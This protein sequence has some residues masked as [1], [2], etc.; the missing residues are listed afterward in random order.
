MIPCNV[1]PASEE[2]ADFIVRYSPRA[3]DSLYELAQTRCVNLVSQEYAIVHAPLSGVLP[4]SFT[5]HTYSAIPKL[6]GLQ[7][8]TALEATGILPVFSQ[9]N[10]MSTGQGILIGMI[11][12][13]IDYTNPLFQ[14]P[15]GTSRILR[16][17]DQTIESENTPEA[18]AG[19]QPFYGTVYSQEDLNRAL[20]SEQPLELVPSTDTSGHGT[21]LA[22]VAAG[23]QI[24]SPTTFSGAAPD[25][26]LAV[27]RLKPA[28][29]YLREFFAVPPDADAYQE[30]DIM[31]AAAF[32]LG[33]AGQYQMP[34]V[35]CLGVGTSQGSHSGISP[36][37]MQLQALSG[38]R[39][40][41]CV[42]GAGN[43]T[44]FRHHYFGNLSPDQE[45]EDVELR[46]ADS[47]SGFSMELWADVSEL[48]T[49]GFVSPSGEVI[50]R[51]PMTVGQETTISF[52]LDATRILISYQITESSSGRFLAFLRFTDPAPG[53]WHI[54]VYP[55]LFVAGQFHIW[56]PMQG[57]LTEDTGFLRP[58]PDITIT[59]PGNAPLLLT[60]STYNHVTGSLYIHSSRGFTATGQ[61]KPDFAAPGVEVQGP[62]IPPGTS[63]L[64]RQTGSSVATAITAGAVACLFSWGFTQGNDT[65]LTSISVKSILIR[66]A[67]RKEAFRYP[68]RQWGYGTLNLYQA[69]LLMRE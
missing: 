17:W 15:D 62:G 27:V 37:A 55:T 53:I 10:L 13:G 60:V 20:A 11:D 67:E 69:F 40:F 19:F 61:I 41:A 48:Y 45:Y 65:T 16:L 51:I 47:T 39:G 68:N 29:Q 54:R 6:Y 30:N 9:P 66:G 63:R 26:A 36:L 14:N 49:V 34:L 18:V 52:Q 43:E 8:T 57:F 2:I 33:V 23:R 46:V 44:G 3:V 12:T 4:L 50:E 25:A 42:T 59:D 7:D 58:D 35:L 22:G 1:S 64:S 21:F 24:Q 28:K 32:L 5:Q 38:T 56:L 31:A